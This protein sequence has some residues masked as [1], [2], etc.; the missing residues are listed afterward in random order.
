[1]NEFDQREIKSIIDYVKIYRG[2]DFNDYAQGSLKRRVVRFFEMRRI[3][4]I[5]EFEFRIKNDEQ[6]ATDF[7]N[8]VTVNVTEMFRDP[9]FWIFLRDQVFPELAKL[10]VIRIWHAA[11][12]TGEEIYSMAILLKEAGLY[13]R[14][15]I[16]AT[17]LNNCAIEH[18]KKGIY[19]IKSQSLNEKNY[20]GFK[21]KMS[22][23]DYY[24]TEDTNVF[25]DPDLIKNVKFMKHNLASDQPFATFDLIICRNVLIYFNFN[26]QDKVLQL[27][28]SSLERGGYLG[29]GSKESIYQTKAEKNFKT[30]SIEEK[31]FKKL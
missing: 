30:E 24:K 28:L 16:V 3:S 11:C 22:L 12:S 5:T 9:T 27:F 17:D 15:R 6:F 4:G 21:G 18:A 7:I 19:K 10:P 23:S 31:I 13:S 26:L 25:Y 14:A 1:M 20:I 8:E 29:I 2:V